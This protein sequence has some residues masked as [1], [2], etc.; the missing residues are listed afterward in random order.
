MISCWI[1][2]EEGLTGTENQCLG[3]AEALGV[4]PDIK[5]IGLRQPW[6][7]FSPWLGFENRYSFT[8]TPLTPPWPDLVIAAGRKSIAAAR[9]VKKMSAG[10]TFTVQLQNPFI[11]PKQFDFVAAPAH[12]QIAGEN[13]LVTKATPNRV[14]ALRLAEAKEEFSSLLSAIPSPRVAVLIGGNSSSYTLSPEIMADLAKK[15]RALSDQGYGLM[16]TASRRTGEENIEL[17]RQAE[18]SAYIWDG[19]GP[20]PYY[21]YLAWADYIIVTSDSA[22]M[23]SEAATTGNPVYLVSLE[24]G[25]RKFNRLHESLKREGI[26][27]DFTGNLEPYEYEPLNDAMTIAK[28]IR[29]RLG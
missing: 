10:R 15:L 7:S 6:R 16:V 17:L 12:D 1:I 11:S 24:G 5:R 3:V 4:Q 21:G 2:T 19:Q 22:S 29:R 8:G 14:S 18:T 25:S 13:V 27:R 9:Y 26:I 28:E 23:I 20:N